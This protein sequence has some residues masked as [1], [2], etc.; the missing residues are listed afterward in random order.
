MYTI[1]EIT[2]TNQANKMSTYESNRR[3]R[4]PQ[5]INTITQEVLP[6]REFLIASYSSGM[7][8][9]GQVMVGAGLDTYAYK[10]KVNIN[11]N[12]VGSAKAD[13]IFGE[14]GDDVIYGG[15]GNDV[16]YGGDGKDKLYG[17]EN[18]D[19]LVGGDQDDVLEGGAGNDT[20][21]GGEGNDTYI[22]NTGDGDDTIED[23]QGINTVKL[24]GEVIS[25]FWNKKNGTSG[26]WEWVN[27][28]GKL[29]A[30]K[31]GTD[32][33]VEHENGMRVTLNEDFEW[34]DF[35]TS[36]VDVPDDPSTTLTITGDLAPI[37]SDPNTPG[38]QIQ[39][40]ALGNVITDPNTPEPDTL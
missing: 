36:L 6:A 5:G 4:P 12:L 13:L 15:E 8:I 38:V 30:Y 23:K 25:V 32:L 31:S 1:H 33:I 37:D 17:G 39:Y 3:T 21:Y 2:E 18:N 24:C 22:I 11:D 9:D 19:L 7:S 26:E 35:G 10:E 40:D 27:T 14:K 20:L 28:S 16:I 34:G 29:R